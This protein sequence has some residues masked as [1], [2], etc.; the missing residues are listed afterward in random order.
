MH[1]RESRIDK[2]QIATREGRGQYHIG[3]MDIAILPN[4]RLIVSR[5]SL[6]VILGLLNRIIP[7]FIADSIMDGLQRGLGA[8][9][10]ES[11]TS[12]ISSRLMTFQNQKMGYRSGGFKVNGKHLTV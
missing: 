2:G 11:V 6:N 12:F 9:H 4:L 3:A 7:L 8:R 10:V 5:I 1:G